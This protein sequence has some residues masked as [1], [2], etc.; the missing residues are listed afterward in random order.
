MRRLIG[1][2]GLCAAGLAA[3]GLT[4]LAGCNRPASPT[5]ANRTVV[6]SIL[7]AEDQQSMAQVWQPLLTDMAKQTGL[8]IKPFYA[9]NY[10][11]L[12]EAMRFKQVQVGWFSALPALEAVNRA[13]GEVIG[14]ILTHGASGAYQSVLITKKGSGIT[15]DT[16]LKCG[17]K[18]TFGMGDAK[19]TSGTL[20]PT[21]YIFTPH[22]IQPADCFKTVRSASHQANF[23]GVA[24]GVLDVAT[25]NT[26]GLIFYTREN[27]ELAA[28]VQVIWT[29]PELPESSIVVRK[30]LDPAVKEK[31]RAFFL[32]YGTGPGK[33]GERERAVL[34]MLT[35]T[36]F[37]PADDRYLDPIRQMEAANALAQAKQGRD[38]AKIAEAQKAYDALQAQMA[39][40]NPAMAPAQP[41]PDA[42]AA[43]K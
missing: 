37:A 16:V 29:S 39:A 17:K 13:D 7:S 15:M 11:S 10:S 3:A 35:Y 12:V 42:P 27:P 1:L 41:V 38:P 9:S 40:H 19:S 14:R 24:T 43:K 21:A 33:E 20:A 8:N 18:L 28:K 36:G 26:V 32:S 23:F 30:D 2:A 6:F 5:S 22:D 31:I 4:L 25:N 34:K